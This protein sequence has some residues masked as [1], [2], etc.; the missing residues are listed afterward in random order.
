MRLGNPDTR[1]EMR[2]HDPVALQPSGKKGK[3]ERLGLE[4]G[5]HGGIYGL[6]PYLLSS[7]Y[8]CAPIAPVCPAGKCEAMRNRIRHVRQE[9]CL[10]QK[11]VVERVATLPGDAEMDQSTLSKIETGDREPSVETLFRIA[12][13][14]DRPVADLLADEDNPERLSE[15]EREVV[16]LWRQTPP[17]ERARLRRMLRAFLEDPTSSSAA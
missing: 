9:C 1:R 17:K 8:G 14:M 2:L 13:A 4:S 15:A 7:G 12:A 6:K 11:Q 5:I 10:T 3:G 16:Q